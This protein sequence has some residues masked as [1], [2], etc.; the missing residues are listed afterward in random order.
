MKRV[1]IIAST[2]SLIAFL[3]CAWS[4]F[5]LFQEGDDLVGTS[6]N[7]VYFFTLLISFLCFR[8]SLGYSTRINP[9][10]AGLSIAII[11]LGTYTWIYPPELLTLGKITLGLIPLLLGTTLMLIVK[12]ASKWSR[13]LQLLLGVIAVTLSS[14]VFLGVNETLIYTFAL[15][16]IILASLSVVAYL[17]FARTS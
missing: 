8:I 15:A 5:E 3:L 12:A 9:I 17:I 13:V 4:L 6:I 16:G 1:R 11:G 2:L 7:L 14:C 10:I